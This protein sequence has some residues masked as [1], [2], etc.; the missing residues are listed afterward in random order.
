ML[1]F[2]RRQRQALR[3]RA[4]ARTEIYVAPEFRREKFRGRFSDSYRI[5]GPRDLLYYISVR[6]PAADRRVLSPNTF[7]DRSG[8][9]LISGPRHYRISVPPDDFSQNVRRTATPRL[10][11]APT[12]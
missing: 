2:V 5:S 12:K 10:K 1:L 7:D 3:G 9:T 8:V 11:A 4:V 6:R